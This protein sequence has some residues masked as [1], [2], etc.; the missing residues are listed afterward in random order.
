MV[1]ADNQ[2][3]YN[4]ILDS[5]YLR[6][7]EDIV[8]YIDTILGYQSDIS[9]IGIKKVLR[10]TIKGNYIV[11]Q[12]NLSWHDIAKIE[13]RTDLYGVEII[14]TEKRRYKYDDVTAHITGYI[15]KPNQN[16][17]NQSQIPNYK[18]FLIGKTGV[19]KSLNKIFSPLVNK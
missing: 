16:E 13:V 14:K 10:S 12:E 11:I 2:Y 9:R 18:S 3:T 6:E 7:I 8:G 1:I 15:A 19:E 17:I 4:L 5:K